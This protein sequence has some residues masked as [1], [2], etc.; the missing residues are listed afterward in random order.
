MHPFN[1]FKFKYNDIIMA[2]DDCF[3][4]LVE[5]DYIVVDED[6]NNIKLAPMFND[7]EG[8]IQISAWPP[9]NQEHK[10]N[11]YRHYI[12]KIVNEYDHILRSKLPPAWHKRINQ[13]YKDLT[14]QYP[15]QLAPFSTPTNYLLPTP[16]PARNM[17]P[18]MG[19]TR[20]NVT[21]AR[22][23]PSSLSSM[24]PKA[25]TPQKLMLGD[26]DE[27]EDEWDP[28]F[29][30]PPRKPNGGKRKK[31]RRRKSRRSKTRRSKTRRSKTR[32][33]KT[34]RSKTRRSKTRRKKSR[35]TRRK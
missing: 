29:A 9:S 6:A 26:M 5:H 27:S 14:R 21:P 3:D 15:E 30:T 13:C 34:R 4:Y 19:Q 1:H 17:V 8:P 23:M 22:N 11:L 25:N 12:I 24:S 2:T 16:T 18:I 7:K 32:R 31:T 28:D 33:S 10:Q 20:Q 35:R